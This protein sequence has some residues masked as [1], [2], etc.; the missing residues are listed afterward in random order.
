MNIK[1]KRVIKATAILGLWLAA[2]SPFLTLYFFLNLANDSSLPGFEQLE[3]PKTNLASVIY[4][5]DIELIGK[6]YQENR[7]NSSYNDL[8]DWLIKALVSTEDERYYEHS[9]LDVRALARVVK[10]VVTG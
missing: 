6:Y 7:T 8:S 10:G 5:T 1:F 3:N 4:T 2:L 9:G